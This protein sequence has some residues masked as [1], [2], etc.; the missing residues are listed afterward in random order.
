MKSELFERDR[1]IIGRHIRKIFNEGELDEALVCAIFA[2]AKK[3]GRRE[4]FTQDAETT[5]YN[6]DACQ[7][8]LACLYI[9]EY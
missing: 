1:T 5:L 2:L 7:V 4:G 6:L 8:S 9:N 3:Y